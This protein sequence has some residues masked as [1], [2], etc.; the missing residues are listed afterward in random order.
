MSSAS[1]LCSSVI[2]SGHSKLYGLRRIFILF[3]VFGV[4]SVGSGCDGGGQVR[5]GGAK[6]QFEG[7][8]GGEGSELSDSGKGREL[9]PVAVAEPGTSPLQLVAKKL[10]FDGVED[11]TDITFLPNGDVSGTSMAL[12]LTRHKELHLVSLREEVAAIEKT[13]L[14]AEAMYT[15]EACAPSNIILDPAFEQNQFIYVSY[16][17]EVT[18]TRLV[19]YRWST[20]TGLSEPA[21]IYES[22]R[23]G[24]TVGWHRFGSMGFEEDEE[25]L[26]MLVGEHGQG[27][28]AR[29]LDSPLGSVVRI[30]P[31]RER[32]GSGHAV[33]KGNIAEVFAHRADA[34]PSIF[35]YGLRSP[36][37]GVR[38]SLGRYWIGDVGA[39]SFEELNLLTKV[40]QDF[41]WPHSEGLCSSGCTDLTDPVISYSHESDTLFLQEQEGTPASE[42]RSIWVGDIYSQPQVDR[43]SGRLDD[44]VVFGDLFTGFVRGLSVNSSGEPEESRALGMV[45]FV[46]AWRQGPDG[47]VYALDLTG[48]LQR[49]VPDDT[50]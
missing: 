30:R 16:C 8:A 11:P 3:A 48:N 12:I 26:W 43:Y 2:W 18:T 6:S 24:A 49:I 42:S 50:P 36:W 25:T 33:A 39:D 40:G 15:G 27:E 31:N 5:D 45:P 20:D 10:E 37:R 13:W 41:A 46:V 29:D 19:R 38:D 21:T 28:L 22:Y 4:S 35:A 32:E 44:V 7:G 17:P 14:F 9:T 23:A 34:D 47:Y 1:S